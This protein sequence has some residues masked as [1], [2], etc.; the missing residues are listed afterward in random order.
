MK[1]EQSL[2]KFR[3]W[4]FNLLVDY[5]VNSGWVVAIKDFKNSE[6]R[7]ERKYLGL[8]DY[9]DDIIYLDKELGTPKVLVHEICHFGLVTV[10][11]KMSEN[12]PWKELKKVKGRFRTN[13]EFEWREL[14]TLEFEELFYNSLTSRQIKILQDF[15]D[16]ARA[17]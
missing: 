11:E 8:T 16:E 15:I 10:L 12:L 7:K 2:R 1:R 6:K 13:K 17:R 14:K 5:F 4:L 3:D 9:E